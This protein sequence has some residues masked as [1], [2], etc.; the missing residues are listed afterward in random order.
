MRLREKE[1]FV[2]NGVLQCLRTWR[3]RC[4]PGPFVLT[5]EDI[6]QLAEWAAKLNESWEWAYTLNKEAGGPLTI[7]PER[8][9]VVR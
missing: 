3:E 1:P 4:E 8:I 9:H 2:A 6:E 7:F 5:A